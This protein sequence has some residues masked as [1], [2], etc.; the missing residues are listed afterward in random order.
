MSTT[1]SAGKDAAGGIHDASA[2]EMTIPDRDREDNASMADDNTKV[3][4]DGEKEVD[5]EKGGAVPAQSPKDETERDANIVDWDGPD[6]PASPPNWPDKDKW[7]NISVLSILT[8][9]T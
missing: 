4:V 9:V 2:K 8:L 1:G 7:L 6:D 5:L 3:A